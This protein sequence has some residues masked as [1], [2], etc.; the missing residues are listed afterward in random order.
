MMFYREN[1]IRYGKAGAGIMFFCENQILLLLRSPAVEEPGTWGIPGGSVAGEG[2]FESTAHTKVDLDI[3]VFWNGALGET[4]EELGSVPTSIEPFDHVIFKE[5]GFI[6]VTFLVRIS[7]LQ[8][9]RWDFTFNWENTDADWFD[10]D[11]L[12][13]DLHFGVQYVINKK[14]NYLR[15][16]SDEEIAMLKQ[17]WE[18]EKSPELY[19]EYINILKNYSLTIPPPESLL[20]GE[21]YSDTLGILHLLGSKD[22]CLPKVWRDFYMSGIKTIDELQRR[23]DEIAGLVPEGIIAQFLELFKDYAAIIGQRELRCTCG[24]EERGHSPDCEFVVGRGDIVEDYYYTLNNW[25]EGYYHFNLFN[26]YINWGLESVFEELTE[27][28]VTIFDIVSWINR[29]ADMD[30]R[31]DITYENNIL[32]FDLQNTFMYEDPEPIAFPPRDRFKCVIREGNCSMAWCVTDPAPV[33]TYNAELALYLGIKN[34]IAEIPLR[35]AEFPFWE[36]R[37]L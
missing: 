31:L 17:Q 34:K 36:W 8:K 33:I 35:I 3:D 27:G 24:G 7:P 19:E 29:T 6:Y 14:L 25:I 18:L 16:P 22:G 5:G 2:W 32:I 12:P 13:D 28:E 30:I 26:Q 23:S 9:D 1:P 15:N 37:A 10:I 21:A 20:C 11:D 4:R